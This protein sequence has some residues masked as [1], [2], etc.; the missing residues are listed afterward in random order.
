MMEICQGCG[1][2]DEAEH[3]ETLRGFRLCPTCAAASKAT[4]N[5]GMTRADEPHVTPW[6][7]GGAFVLYTALAWVFGLIFLVLGLISLMKGSLG[8]GLLGCLAGALL[9]AAPVS[10]LVRRRNRA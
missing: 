7:P 3:M 2:K 1:R 5:R 9:V 10:R 8:W 4:G 6:R